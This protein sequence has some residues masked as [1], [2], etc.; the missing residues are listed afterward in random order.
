[1][2]V[3]CSEWGCS[4]ELLQ[5]ASARAETKQI[6]NSQ[7]NF[8]VWFF[9]SFLRCAAGE[10]FEPRTPCARL[11]RWFSPCCESA[12][13]KLFRR[14]ADP[15]PSLAFSYSRVAAPVNGIRAGYRPLGKIHLE[16]SKTGCLGGWIG[17]QRISPG[18][19]RRCGKASASTG[20]SDFIGSSRAAGARDSRV[21]PR[22]V[23]RSLSVRLCC[24]WRIDTWSVAPGWDE[25][26]RL[27]LWF[28]ANGPIDASLGRCPRNQGPQIVPERRWRG[29]SAR[30][31]LGSVAWREVHCA[32]MGRVFSPGCIFDSLPGALP[33]AGMRAR[34]WR[35]GAGPKGRPVAAWGRFKRL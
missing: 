4:L 14:Q 15:P 28:R 3:G 18:P 12:R 23:F 5:A 31:G 8:L 10:R 11:I 19:I 26:A 7:V 13:R 29:P 25:C 17:W 22:K 33:Q 24:C 30:K 21:R 32:R 34:R 9:M 1:L 16:T 6:A 20:R 2:V 35:F 27:A